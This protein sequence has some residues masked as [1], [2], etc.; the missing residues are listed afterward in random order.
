MCLTGGAGSSASAGEGKGMR[1]DA[2][3]VAGLRR[4]PGCGVSGRGRAPK[5]GRRGRPGSAIGLDRFR[6]WAGLGVRVLAQAS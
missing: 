6:C 2:G 4:G 1:V 3:L 5:A